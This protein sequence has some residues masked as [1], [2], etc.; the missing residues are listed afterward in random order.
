MVFN[1]SDKNYARIIT[2]VFLTIA[3]V[4][5]LGI[6]IL[7]VLGIKDFSD[8]FVQPSTSKIL[9]I[10][11]SNDPKNNLNH[12]QGYDKLVSGSK[13]GCDVND[14]PTEKGKIEVDWEIDPYYE[15]PLCIKEQADLDGLNAALD[16]QL[17][18]CG[19]YKPLGES[20]VDLWQKAYACADYQ[21]V[22][23]SIGIEWED[24]G[25]PPDAECC[26][27]NVWKAHFVYIEDVCLISSQLPTEED[28][29]D[30]MD[31]SIISRPTCKEVDFEFN[32]AYKGCHFWTIPASDLHFPESPTPDK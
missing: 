23:G 9:S 18:I 17:T 28:I 16:Y 21:I 6:I 2:G 1:N 26:C 4:T 32:I 7:G 30:C 11:E 31:L 5:I 20:Y 14:I 24:L 19:G 15:L 27:E 22:K 10:S 3:V 13:I 29:P 8:G 12:D 25:H